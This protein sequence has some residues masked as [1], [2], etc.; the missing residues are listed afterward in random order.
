MAEVR[1]P[2]GVPRER[3]CSA[4]RGSGRGGK[5]PLATVPPHALVQRGRDRIRDVQRERDGRAVLRQTYHS[6]AVRP[7]PR[8]GGAGHAALV[9]PG[10]L[11]CL[12]GKHPTVSE[13]SDVGEYIDR[14]SRRLCRWTSRQC[15][16][17][18]RWTRSSSQPGMIIGVF[19][20]RVSILKE[21]SSQPSQPKH[22]F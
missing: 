3:A 1:G 14:F 19:G 2:V 8:L 22:V 11:L 7:L 16:G 4:V 18:R 21:G 20:G 9:P 12:Q 13:L 10:R 5:L 6:H 15:C 17:R